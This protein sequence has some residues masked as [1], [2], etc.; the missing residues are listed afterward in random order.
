MVDAPTLDGGDRRDSGT[1]GTLSAVAGAAEARYVVDHPSICGEVQENELG[2]VDGGRPTSLN[3]VNSLLSL[4][5]QSRKSFDK[6]AEDQAELRKKEMLAE[7]YDEDEL[8]AI[9][10]EDIY[11]DTDGRIRRRLKP[12]ASTAA[13]RDDA[14]VSRWWWSRV[15]TRLRDEGLIPLADLQDRFPPAQRE[16]LL[17]DREVELDRARRMG[18]LSAA[19]KLHPLHVARYV[20]TEL[21]S[22]FIHWKWF[23]RFIL[24]VIALNSVF[25]ALTDY[26]S[27]DSNNNLVTEGSPTNTLI[28]GSEVF[29]TVIFAAEMIIKWVALGI[30]L[31]LQEPWNWL[32]MTVVL[33][34]FISVIPGLPNI[35]VFR[36]FRVLRPLKSIKQLPKVC[37]SHNVYF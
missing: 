9:K 26:S 22:A 24:L 14:K 18:E 4:V 29:F 21:A 34:A 37:A 3:A 11:E 36:T 32:D 30:P 2:G 1:M 28:D 17:T 7:G 33:M 31:Y 19:Y 27:V 12:G 25:I 10:D 6:L 20:M 16:N 8:E 13:H 5:G 23:D 15:A 35:K